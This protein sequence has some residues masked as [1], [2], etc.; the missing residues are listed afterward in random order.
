MANSTYYTLT[1]ADARY[2]QA[3][4]A[5]AWRDWLTRHIIDRYK[6]HLAYYKLQQRGL[7]DNPD[8]RI[9]NDIRQYVE[10]SL[11]LLVTILKAFLDTAVFAWVLCSIKP[12]LLGVLACYA[13]FGTVLTIKLGRQ[14]S[15]LNHYAPLRFSNFGPW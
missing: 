12:E 2:Q 10:L 4:L 15:V 9:A 14:L 5:V 6:S 7:A 3:E 11:A 1:S 13:L 8:E